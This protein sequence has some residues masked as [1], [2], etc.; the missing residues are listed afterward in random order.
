MSIRDAREAEWTQ[1]ALARHWAMVTESEFL[2]VKQAHLEAMENRLRRIA[3]LYEE[4][5]PN[6]AS[7]RG[8]AQSRT[9]S[10]G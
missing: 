3:S 6:S 7:F 10:E 4:I 9:H 8:K 2:E 5:A 1:A